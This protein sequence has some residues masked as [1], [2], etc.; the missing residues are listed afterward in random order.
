MGSSDVVQWASTTSV[1]GALVSTASVPGLRTLPLAVLGRPRKA[2]GETRVPVVALTF[3]A[4]TTVVVV[5]TMAAVDVSRRWVMAVAW[6]PFSIN[7]PVVPRVYTGSS[8][9]SVSARWVFHQ[10]KV[11]QHPEGES[12]AAASSLRTAGFC[13]PA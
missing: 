11:H 5:V 4:S 12:P 9:T 7:D 2:T 8:G 3:T 10:V 6:C 13:L 1:F